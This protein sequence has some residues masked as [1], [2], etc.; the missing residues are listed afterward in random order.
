LI[1]IAASFFTRAS[2]AFA[3]ASFAC[4]EL[5]ATKSKELADSARVAHR[6][7]QQPGHA[8]LRGEHQVMPNAVLIVPILVHPTRRP[9]DEAQEHVRNAAR[10]PA[11]VLRGERCQ[12]V[13]A[14]AKSVVLVPVL[15]VREP[16]NVEEPRVK[17]DSCAELVAIDRVVVSGT[18]PRKEHRAQVVLHGVPVQLEIVIAVDEG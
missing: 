11:W 3:F 12:N 1:I 16:R 5:L 14:R 2:L 6:E 13:L 18:R 8:Q 15:D 4:G 10:D 7:L 9:N 17:R